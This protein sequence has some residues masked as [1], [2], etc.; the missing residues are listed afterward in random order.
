MNRQQFIQRLLGTSGIISLFGTGCGVGRTL[1]PD[2]LPE[3][4]NFTPIQ[5]ATLTAKRA[6]NVANAERGV[7]EAFTALDITR[8]TRIPNTIGPQNLDWFS[9]RRAEVT[10]V[11]AAEITLLVP[12]GTTLPEQLTLTAILA[13]EWILVEQF[14]PSD[15]KFG[16]LPPLTASPLTY[17]R[18]PATNRYQSPAPLIVMGSDYGKL[19]R[20][21]FFWLTQ[22]DW[23]LRPATLTTEIR[24]KLLSDSLPLDSQIRFTVGE[25]RVKMA[26]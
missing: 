10:Q 2:F 21:F 15:L 1:Q 7:Y 19:S 16:H 6:E 22:G 3:W 23:Y 14:A 9:L 26:F 11:F 8:H 18:I 12:E 5:D 13:E 25:N 4:I 17:T 20:E 24:F